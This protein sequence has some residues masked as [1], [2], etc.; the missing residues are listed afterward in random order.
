MSAVLL[1]TVIVTTVLLLGGMAVGA[2]VRGYLL[3]P[4]DRRRLSEL[5]SQLYTQASIDLTT[6]ASLQAMHDI[7]RTHREGR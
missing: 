7:V 2:V 6:R 5:A 1:L 4:S 3:L